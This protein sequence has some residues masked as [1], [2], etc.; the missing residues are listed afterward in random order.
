MIQV[1]SLSKGFSG[2]T[3]F[4][5]LSFTLPEKGLFLLSGPNGCGKSTL[6][7]LLAGLDPDYGGKILYDG[8]DLSSL[9]EEERLLFRKENISLLFSHGNLF[10][11]LTGK[12]NLLYDGKGEKSSLSEELLSKNPSVLSGGEEAL[13]SLETEFSKNKRICLIDELTSA[14]N[15]ENVHKVMDVIRR[16]SADSLILMATHDKRILSEGERIDMGELIRNGR[17]MG[18][19]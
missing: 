5:N 3:L 11:F 12:E 4:R 15:E 17:K 13:L 18:A 14:L 1:I 10:S 19:E 2:K 7:Y 8:R 16:Q 9:S 6:L